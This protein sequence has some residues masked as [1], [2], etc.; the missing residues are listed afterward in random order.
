MYAIRA[1]NLSKTFRSRSGG[2]A[3][4]ALVDVSLE[5]ERGD[6]V[7]VMGPSGSGK[8]TLLSLLAL[9]ERPDAGSV[10]IGG[11]D[12]ATLS[13][14]RLAEFRRRSIGFVF[15]DASLLDTLN[16]RENVS[17]PLAL[18]RRPSAEIDAKVDS[19]AHDLGIS[20]VLAKYPAEVSGGERQRA[21]A[22]RALAAEPAA[23]LADEPTGSLDSRSGRDLLER[24]V[25]L[26]RSRGSAVLMATHDPYAAAWARRV[27]FLRDGRIFTEIRSGS[28]QRAFFERVLEVQASMEGRFR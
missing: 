5:V 12:S 4:A 13:G 24:F 9:I 22:A 19:L 26:N 10:E 25:A 16:L 18:G 27:V 1:R 11:V 17:L 3:A 20:G 21:A 8:T 15:Q 2:P 28:D 14:D 7:A 6:F 23:L